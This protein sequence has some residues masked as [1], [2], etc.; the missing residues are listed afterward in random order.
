MSSDG[1]KEVRILF[2]LEQDDDG[3]PPSSGET[4]WALTTEDGHYA[5]D[6]IPFFV[7]GIS[8]FDV[9]SAHENDGF[10]VFDKLIQSLGHSTFRVVVYDRADVKTVRDTLKSMG[11][12]CEQSHIP[13]L[14]SVDVPPKI[15]LSLIQ[16]YLAQ[17]VSE[18]KWDYEA[19]CLVQ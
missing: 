12:A 17:G 8:C 15:D 4:M 18:E 14:F 1:T 16:A 6:N 2:D 11:C 13:S 5:I 10:L 9:V 7:Y 3:Y 19:A